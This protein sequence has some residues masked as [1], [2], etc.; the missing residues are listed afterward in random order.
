[1]ISQTISAYTRLDIRDYSNVQNSLRL[2]YTHTF[3]DENVLSV[4]ADYMHDYLF[5]T[6]LEGRVRKQDSFDAFAQYD[7]N[8]NKYWEIVGALRYDYFSD[9]HISRL[10]PKV[11]ARYQTNKK[12]KYSTQLWHGFPCTN[13]KR[14]VLQL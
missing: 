6:N 13:T 8:I 4:G 5:N 7:W 2:L 9:G 12:P 11:S 1:M 10:T 3:E 14:K